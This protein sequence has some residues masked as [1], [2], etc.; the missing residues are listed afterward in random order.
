MKQYV[1]TPAAGKRLIA[2]ALA[3]HPQVTAALRSGTL[4]IVAGTTNAYVAQEV[5]ATLGEA[6]GFSAKGFRRGVVCPPHVKADGG[7]FAGDVI[8]RDGK[9]LKGKQIF[10]VADDLGPDDLILKGANALDPRG[11]PA[12][13]IGHPQAGTAGAVIAAVAGRGTKLI[14]PVGLEKRIFEDV[15]SLAA[16]ID[17]GRGE[18]PGL[19]PLPGEA[20]TEF[21]AVELLTGACLRLLAAGGVHGAEGALWVGVEGT[22]QQIS[23]ADALL[24]EVGK[25]PPCEY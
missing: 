3:E 21:E 4:A 18:G 14:V 8:I 25:E 9:W 19:L 24:R 10:D 1:I 16:E 13:L 7:E 15:D 22:E 12:V 6:D 5:L 20:F 2:K 11:R 23:A 17:P